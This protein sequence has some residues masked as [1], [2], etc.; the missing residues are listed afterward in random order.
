[1]KNQAGFKVGDNVSF[2]WNGQLMNGIVEKLNPKTVKIRVEGMGLFGVSPG[3]LT[4][5]ADVRSV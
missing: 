1:M 5:S 2:Q 4:V 3:L